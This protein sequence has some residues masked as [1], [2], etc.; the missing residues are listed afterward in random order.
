MYFFWYFSSHLCWLPRYLCLNRSCL[1]YLLPPLPLSFWDAT[2]LGGWGRQQP[3][4]TRSATGAPGGQRGPRSNCRGTDSFPQTSSQK[5]TPW[6]EVSLSLSLKASSGLNHTKSS[7]SQ[8]CHA[9]SY[10]QPFTSAVSYAWKAPLFLE[11]TQ[12]LFKTQLKCHLILEDFLNFSLSSSP[13]CFHGNLS[14]LKSV[15]RMF[16]SLDWGPFG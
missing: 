3:W 10:P 12:L 2:R 4:E 16:L 15:T 9:L 1:S 6:R 5:K 7:I 11:D 14:L 8:T 13:L